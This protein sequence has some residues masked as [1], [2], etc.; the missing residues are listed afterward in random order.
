MR[1]RDTAT[2]RIAGQRST[3]RTTFDQT[4]WK[5][6]RTIAGWASSETWQDW[7]KGEGGQRRLARKAERKAGERRL[8]RT[9]SCFGPY[10]YQTV[11]P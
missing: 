4:W 1:M 5:T 6:L 7:C 8:R 10:S 11:V 3:L 2:G 9:T